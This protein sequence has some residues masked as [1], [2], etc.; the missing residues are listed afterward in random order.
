MD[1]SEVSKLE[2][3]SNMLL[4]TLRSFIRATGGELQLIVIFPDSEP[5]DI[6]GLTRGRLL[7]PMCQAARRAAVPTPRWPRHPNPA[8]A[9]LQVRTPRR[10]PRCQ[11]G[12]H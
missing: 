9:H 1:Q 2:R 7:S 3:C 8:Q 5:F 12:R 6:D 4:S 11:D 10:V